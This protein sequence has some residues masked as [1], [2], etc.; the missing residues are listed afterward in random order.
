[1]S[2]NEIMP[3]C[4]KIIDRDLSWIQDEIVRSFYSQAILNRILL[5]FAFWQKSIL[6]QDNQNLWQEN[7]HEHA[8][9]PFL[10][11]LSKN[12]TG[13]ERLWKEFSLS[14]L[15]QKSLLFPTG[16]SLSIS[17]I[18]VT[19]TAYANVFAKLERKTER[20]GVK[21]LRELFGPEILGEAFEFSLTKADKKSKGVFYTPS[22]ITDGMT[23]L[24][25]EDFIITHLDEG[26]IDTAA[27]NGFKTNKL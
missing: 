19:D 12:K 20:K 15:P 1:M 21:A 8:M 6:F 2:W 23:L 22:Y 17:D 18:Q 9:I 16:G 7:F 25:I 26:V 11:R 14:A 27:S 13:E 3:E 24:A 10:K 4:R 5:I